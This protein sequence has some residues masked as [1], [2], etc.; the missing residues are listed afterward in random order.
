MLRMYVI[1]RNKTED[2]LEE[3]IEMAGELYPMSVKKL[4]GNILSKSHP[5]TTGNV[6]TI[7]IG[8][9]P[10]CSCPDNSKGNQCK[11][12]V[13]VSLLS[14]TMGSIYQPALFLVFDRSLPLSEPFKPSTIH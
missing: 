6:Y 12:I 1:D 8:L 2:S 10:A 3:T 11:H 4:I 5:G 14:K 13:Y 9:V 7:K